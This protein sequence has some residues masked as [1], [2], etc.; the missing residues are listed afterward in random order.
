MKSLRLSD[1]N[2]YFGTVGRLVE[3]KTIK[4]LIQAFSKLND[5][6]KLVIIGDGR[7]LDELKEIAKDLGIEN[8]VHFLGKVEMAH[9]YLKSF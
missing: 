2:F 1:N 5:N 9:R 7:L 3:K 8:R 6:S 4:I